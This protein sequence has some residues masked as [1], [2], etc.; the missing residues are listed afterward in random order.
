MVNDDNRPDI[1][2]RP[3]RGTTKRDM[4]IVGG[5]VAVIL[6]AGL[7]YAL[8]AP[9]RPVPDAPTTPPT[10]TRTPDRPQPA[11]GGPAEPALPSPQR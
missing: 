10:Q 3:D 6:V 4:W 5:I 11:P 2:L 1:R 9:Q 8:F 7:A